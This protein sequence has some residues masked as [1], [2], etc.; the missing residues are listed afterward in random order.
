[1]GLADVVRQ[2]DEF[3]RAVARIEAN[4]VDDP[5]TPANKLIANMN[6]L[7]V[8]SI[9]MQSRAL[10]SRYCLRSQSLRFMRD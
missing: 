9:L 6:R 3:E 4:A 5:P 2:I 1:M 10:L 7:I 8:L